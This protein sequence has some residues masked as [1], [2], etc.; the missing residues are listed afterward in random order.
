MGQAHL[1]AEIELFTGAVEGF[2]QRLLDLLLIGDI[3]SNTKQVIC[4]PASSW[5]KKV[6]AKIQRKLPSGRRIR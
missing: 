6:R 4:L 5:S 2:K 1:V 3:L